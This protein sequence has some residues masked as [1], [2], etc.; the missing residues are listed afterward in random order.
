MELIHKIITT[1]KNRRRKI[2]WFN[3][4]FGLNITTKIDKYFLNLITKHFPTHHKFHKIFN[5]NKL[6]ISY[7]CMPNIRTWIIG[8]MDKWINGQDK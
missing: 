2:I 7:S 6:K 3:P 4:P 5:R 8:H 1:K